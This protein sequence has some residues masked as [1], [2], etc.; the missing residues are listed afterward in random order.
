MIMG[1]QAFSYDTLLYF[2]ELQNLILPHKRN[3]YMSHHADLM[4]PPKCDQDFQRSIIDLQQ[5]C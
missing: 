3:P 4:S 2:L 1:G 5:I